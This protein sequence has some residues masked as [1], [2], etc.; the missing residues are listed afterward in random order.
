MNKEQLRKEAADRYILENHPDCLGEKPVQLLMR[1]KLNLAHKAGAE[2]EAERDKW[3]S[4]DDALPETIATL[5]RDDA[6]DLIPEQ[7]FDLICLTENGE[8]LKNRRV[9]MRVGE[10]EWRWLWNIKDDTITHF[11]L[12]TPPKSN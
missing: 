1:E 12:F 3:I 6:D 2:W 10:K 8:S 11:K 4:V 9:R 7:T 5:L